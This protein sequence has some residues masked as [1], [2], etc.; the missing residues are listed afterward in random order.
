M[1]NEVAKE[2]TETGVGKMSC[3]ASIGADLSGPI[4][5]AKEGKFIVAID[6]CPISCAKKSLERAGI[7]PDLS[8]VVT[9]LGVKK[10]PGPK[11]E[12]E[13]VKKIASEIVGKIRAACGTK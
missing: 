8:F 10:R 4:K 9:E 3:L 5:A 12:H 7:K 11:A 13:D 6:G 2:L 1:T